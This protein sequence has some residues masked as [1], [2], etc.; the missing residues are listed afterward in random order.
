MEIRHLVKTSN[1]KSKK[2]NSKVK[3]FTKGKNK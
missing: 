1:A 3:R 2:P